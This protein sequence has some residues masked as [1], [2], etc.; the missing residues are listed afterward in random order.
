LRE[1][2]FFPTLFALAETASTD[3]VKIRCS[4][5]FIAPT[6][7]SLCAISSPRSLRIDTTTVYSQGSPS[8]GWRMLPSMRSGV[9]A[10]AWGSSAP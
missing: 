5:G 6:P 4:L 3:R 1:P 9:T 10:G 7:I 8:A 2:L